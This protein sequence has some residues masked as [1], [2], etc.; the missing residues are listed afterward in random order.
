MTKTLT[1]Q[2]VAMYFG[3]K[4]TY[5]GS[6]GH[7]RTMG[8]I[9]ITHNLID[10]DTQETFNTSKCY[11]ILRRLDKITDE[12][13]IACIKI[14]DKGVIYGFGTPVYKA[15]KVKSFNY[16]KN[17]SEEQTC[18]TIYD[19]IG[20]SYG[21]YFILQ[22]QLGIEEVDFLRSKGY[23]CGA[24]EIQSLIECGLAID[25]SKID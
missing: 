21:Q 13:A 19:K 3:A 8:G 9:A 18:I 20:T 6:Y 7:I 4:F 22:S 25:G 24:G 23:D 5:R 15:E 16:G 12:D 11:L 10:D 2:I 17:I 1:A 14:R